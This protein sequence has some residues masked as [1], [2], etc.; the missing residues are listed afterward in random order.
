[1]M[2]AQF[3]TMPMSTSNHAISRSGSSVEW[4]LW[5]KHVHVT[6][7]SNLWNAHG[8]RHENGSSIGQ[9]MSQWLC[10][11]RSK[12]P[13]PYYQCCPVLVVSNMHVSFISTSSH[14]PV[15]HV[16]VQ[17]LP[18]LQRMPTGWL[19]PMVSS[20]DR[21]E[22]SGHWMSSQRGN[23]CLTH[24]SSPLSPLSKTYI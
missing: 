22:S 15:W 16:R 1:M 24:L 3:C 4:V 18:P 21:A 14:S 13:V 11:F 12:V 5:Q 19:F 6:H 10:L 8:Q 20:H 23:P 2:V 7:Q 9:E 17:P